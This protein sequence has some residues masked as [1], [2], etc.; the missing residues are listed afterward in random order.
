ME[1]TALVLVYG[2]DLYGSKVAPT[3]GFD[4]L[5]FRFEMNMDDDQLPNK[6][7]KLP[8]MIKVTELEYKILALERMPLL[9]SKEKER[10]DSI[11]E[12]KVLHSSIGLNILKTAKVPR[13]WISENNNEYVDKA[14][15]E[16][17]ELSSDKKGY[18]NA[19]FQFRS[20]RK[21]ELIREDPGAKLDLKEISKEWKSMNDTLKEPYIK[22][23]EEEKKQI[24]KKV[25]KS[26]LSKEEKKERKLEIDRKYRLKVKLTNTKKSVDDELCQKKFEEVLEGRNNLMK[27]ESDQS[28]NLKVSEGKLKIEN[29]LVLEMIKEKESEIERLKDRYKLLHK[30]HKSC[31][32]AKH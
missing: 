9:S 25:K 4:I 29:G 22:K 17:E 11:R 21:K 32:L 12:Q 6:R 14:V 7:K 15:G 26:D 20:E 23:A 1:S 16:N 2:M 3:K 31:S 28:E 27:K 5:A 19:Y 18:S 13:E 8:K 24:G 10:L 30:V